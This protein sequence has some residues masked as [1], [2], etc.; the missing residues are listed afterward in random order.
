[1]QGMNETE[2]SEEAVVSTSCDD[3]FGL[4]AQSEISCYLSLS[5]S[6]IEKHSSEIM[7]WLL[8]KAVNED[9]T[10]LQLGEGIASVMQGAVS[11]IKRLGEVNPKYLDEIYG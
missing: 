7:T 10:P 8:E 5:K 11:Q 6:L 4:S 2:H 3:I 1:M 9:W